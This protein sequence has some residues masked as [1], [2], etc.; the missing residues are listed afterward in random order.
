MAKPFLMSVDF[1]GATLE[2]SVMTVA[3]TAVALIGTTALF[4]EVDWVLIASGAGL[5]GAISILTSIG[6]G[7]V[8]HGNPSLAG[9][10]LN[11]E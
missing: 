7:S 1:W 4:H 10:K 6:K 8:N 9:E 5:A 2:R 11:R 3:Q